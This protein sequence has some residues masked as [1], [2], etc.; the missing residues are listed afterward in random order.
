MPIEL[1]HWRAF[2][3]AA[4]TRHFGSAAERLGI[5]QSAL[6]QLI[7]AL[8][9]HLHMQLFDRTHRRV[10]LTET[11]HMVLPEANAALAQMQRAER[12][13]SAV[14]RQNA[15]VLAAGYVG[16]AALHPVFPALIGAIAAAR[17][18]ISLRLDQCP[19]SEQARLLGE[20]LLDL[21]IARSPLPGLDPEIAS[22]TLAREKMIVAIAASHPLAGTAPSSL[23]QFAEEPFIQYLHQSSGGLRTLVASACRT[24]GFEPVVTQTVPQIT[25]MLCLVGAGVGVALVPETAMRLGVPGVAY[26]PIRER[27]TTELALLHRRSDTA[28]AFRT[29]LR[30]ARK[31]TDK[32]SL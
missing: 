28:P 11:G 19:A 1:R 17:P 4:E 18:N 6:S 2:V 9:S 23:A 20:H 10:R 8:E 5:S 21:G 16:S 14:G 12:F 29:V 30:L 26:R 22:L 27:V 13:A 25:T 3:A 7:Q 15:G 31:L 24:A 32:N